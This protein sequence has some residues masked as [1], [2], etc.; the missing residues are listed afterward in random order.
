M[1]KRSLSIILLSLFLCFGFNSFAQ[2]DSRNRTAETV[3]S[4]GLAQLPA[5]NQ[6]T[7]N[8]VIGEMA[9]TGQKGIEMLAAMLKPADTN[10]NALFEYAID[11]IV[12]YVTRSDNAALQQQIHDGL[13]AGL[14][15]CTD[16]PNRAFLMTQLSKLARPGDAEVFASYL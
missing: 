1:N 6:A 16:D 14:K 8:E 7:Y 15:K 10:Q 9:A 11:A 5:K 12:S 2:L 13:V 3:I 4:D